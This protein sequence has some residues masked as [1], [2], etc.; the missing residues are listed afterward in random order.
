MTTATKITFARLAL[1]PVFAAFAIAYSL[2]VTSSQ[3][4]E[5]WRYLAMATFIT[6]ALGD[7][8]D[9]YIARKF[10]QRSKLGAFMDPLA[11]KTLLLTGVVVLTFF[12]W[13]RDEWNIP[14]WFLAII[15]GRDIIMIAGI[16]VLKILN[17]YVPMSPH[18]VG[19]VCTVTQM[20]LLAWVMLKIIPISPIYP[21]LLA[22]FFTL[23]SGVI[24]VKMGIQMRPKA[25]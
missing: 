15:V 17:G 14:L 6:A 24:Y 23:V 18:W 4:A 16:S 2:S 12:P 9:G 5:I 8:L 3:P 21:A 13:G 1:V 11:D 25:K 19:K 7:G 10:N 20:F 22:A